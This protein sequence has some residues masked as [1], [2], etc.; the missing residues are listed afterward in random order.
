MTGTNLTCEQFDAFLSDFL[1]GTVEP[2][3]RSSMDGHRVT[4]VRCAALV[5]DIEDL[6]V[7]AAALPELAPARDL[8][9][10]ISGRIDTGVVTTPVFGEPRGS[11]ASAW[12]GQAR[13]T[14]SLRK[15][16]VAAAILMAATSAATYFATM[17]RVRQLGASGAVAIQPVPDDAVTAIDLP[18]TLAPPVDS[19]VP[20]GAGQA[21]GATSSGLTSALPTASK[22]RAPASATYDREIAKL[23]DV[24]EQRRLELDPSTIAI[25]QHSLTTI[26]IAIQDA[27][28]ALANDP[29]S[30][31]LNQ[32]LN[33]ALE[34]KLGLLRRVALLPTR[35]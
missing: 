32:Q 35:A 28:R 11:R 13:R 19:G 26:D 29:S 14:V 17:A 1:E 6:R 23:R 10:E 12:S 25:I 33:N 20:S 27:R 8:W 9:A 2:A 24:V 4:C 34:K 31:F 30:R 7:D 21:P 5:R 18:P 3:T 15:W 22:G 16:G